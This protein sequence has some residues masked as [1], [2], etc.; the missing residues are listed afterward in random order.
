[1]QYWL[2]KTEPST[3]SID[4]L[5]REGVGQWDGVRNYQARNFLRDTVKVGDA[6]LFYHSS[7]KVP[8][9]A[10]VAR[11]VKEGYPDSTQF[12]PQ[13]DHYDAKSTRDNPLWYMVDIT[14]VT[15]FEYVIPLVDLHKET[16]LKGMPLLMRG[17][18][19]SI[20]PVSKKQ[21]DHILKIAK[22]VSSKIY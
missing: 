8:G 4:D 6:V 14:L 2:F 15:K 12:D 17:Q 1:M 5:A 10:G 7:T 13:D 11:V 18:R 21:F 20:Q 16:A 9:V 19:L 3:Y 22:V